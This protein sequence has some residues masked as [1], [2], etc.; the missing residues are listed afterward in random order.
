MVYTNNPAAAHGVGGSSLDRAPGYLFWDDVHPTREAH[1]LLGE[2]ALR[3]VLPAGDYNRDGITDTADYSTWATQYGVAFDAAAGLTP[4]LAGDANGDG[5]INA[6]D[7]TAWRDVLSA[8]A[9]AIPEPHSIV[10]ALAALVLCAGV[11]VRSRIAVI[12]A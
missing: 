7:Y 10:T 5:Q 9:P 4:S 8:T 2:A 12:H 1:I 3:T 11:R 6:A